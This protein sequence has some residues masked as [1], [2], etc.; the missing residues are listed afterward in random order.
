LAKKSYIGAYVGRTGS[1]K[2]SSVPSHDA[3][4]GPVSAGAAVSAAL[5]APVVSLGAAP[6]PT[7]PLPS[8]PP[9][10]ATSRAPVAD[11]L[12]VGDGA[13]EYAITNPASV[14]V[15]ALA[16]TYRAVD[17]HNAAIELA[18]S[19]MIAA[20]V[21]VA[22]IPWG[23]QVDAELIQAVAAWAERCGGSMYTATG[24]GFWLAEDGSFTIIED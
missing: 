10:D 22:S 17:V 23:A 4:S 8:P 2:L 7:A 24:R 14:A 11:A 9:V 16:T 19:I 5:D 20:D 6:P 15:R 12:D 21:R 1:G 3:Q 13:L 18:E